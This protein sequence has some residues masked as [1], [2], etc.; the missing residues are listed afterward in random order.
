MF[1]L[2]LQLLQLVRLFPLFRLSLCRLHTG[3]PV[4]KRGLRLGVSLLCWPFVQVQ[5]S[6]REMASH[7]HDLERVTLH[8][9]R[10]TLRRIHPEHGS[11]PF[12]P[13]SMLVLDQ[14]A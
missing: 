14:C 11:R 13:R 10:P 5:L 3:S 4:G 1:D 8:L 2:P 12:T 9:A 6:L 7:V